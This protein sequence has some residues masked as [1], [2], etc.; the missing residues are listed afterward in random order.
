MKVLLIGEASGVHRN[1]KKGLR[2]HGVEA[3][4]L[5]TSDSA[6]WKWYDGA[7]APDWPGKLGG[8]ARNVAPFVK[9]AR[10]PDYDVANFINTITAVH[11]LWTRYWDIPLI[12]RKA[13]LM[14]YY[15]LGC[16]E[17]A[18]IRHNPALPYTPCQTC[19]ASGEVLGRDCAK[20]LNPRFAQSQALVRRH[21]DFGASSML[22]YGHTEALFPGRFRRIPFP[23][24]AEPIAFRPARNRPRPLIVHTPTRR[25]FKGTSI[26]LD[27]MDRLGRRRGDFEFRVVEGLSYADYLAAMGEA[28]V[29]I[30]QVYSQSS[31]MNGLEMLAAG[32]VMLTGSTPLGRAYFPFGDESPAIDAPPDA[33]EL[34]QAVSN[35]LDRKSEFPAL[36]EAGRVYVLKHHDPVKVAGQFLDGWRMVLEQR[37]AHAA[38]QLG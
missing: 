15:A 3:L 30:D 32:K 29:V 17:I 9:I 28:D 37:Q 20:L 13:K 34:A 12:R 36:A 35:L 27:A 31:G 4:H 16:D 38:A 14:S 11:G 19:L 24:D 23:V 25:G 1:L 22:E 2:E 10:M 21:F 26:V 18:L 33:A 5:V 8:I 6:S 7:F